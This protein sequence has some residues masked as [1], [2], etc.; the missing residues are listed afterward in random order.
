MILTCTFGIWKR[1]IYGWLEG[2]T[3]IINR[4][5]DLNEL[6]KERV[7][8]GITGGVLV[9]SA[10]NFEDT[11]WMFEVICKTRL[12]KRRCWMVAVNGTGKN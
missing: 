7:T 4:T 5:Y 1:R 10:N 9:Q 12:D 2:D 8:A 6:S 3:T 11:D